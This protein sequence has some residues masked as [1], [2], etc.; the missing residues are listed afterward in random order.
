MY[1]NKLHFDCNIHWPCKVSI[2]QESG[3]V[4]VNFRKIISK[5]WENYGTLDQTCVKIP[6]EE[7]NRLKYVVMNKFAVNHNTCFMA[8]QRSDGVKQTVPIG[9]HINVYGQINGEE[10]HSVYIYWMSFSVFYS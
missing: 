5:V 9:W 1:T 4:E 3:K 7:Q 6:N 2:T 8:L 10:F